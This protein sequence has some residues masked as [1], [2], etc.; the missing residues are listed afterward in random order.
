[1]KKKRAQPQ[2]RDLKY[3]GGNIVK[4]FIEANPT[5]V[6]CGEWMGFKVFSSFI[7]TYLEQQEV[8]RCKK[9]VG[10]F[11]PCYIGIKQKTQNFSTH[12]QSYTKAE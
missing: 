8:R 10:H 5:W 2:T 1:M 6:S 4:I 11:L 9:P 7:N 3:G 12:G